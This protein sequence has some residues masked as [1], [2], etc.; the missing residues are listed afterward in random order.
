[1]GY[2]VKSVLN[3]DKNS[4]LQFMAGFHNRQLMQ[5]KKGEICI[6]VETGGNRKKCSRRVERTRSIDIKNWF[7][8]FKLNRNWGKLKEEGSC[9]N[10]NFFG[11]L[12]EVSWFVFGVDICG[13]VPQPEGWRLALLNIMH[14]SIRID[15]ILIWQI[16]YENIDNLFVLMARIR[17]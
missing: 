1:M 3:A 16:F 15:S 7:D 10:F 4:F 8:L 13:G 9:A 5:C 12:C 14:Y 11:L 6:I 2:C 17:S